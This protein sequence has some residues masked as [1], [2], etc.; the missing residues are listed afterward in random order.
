MSDGSSEVSDLVL[1]QGSN[2]LQS[3]GQLHLLT[4]TVLLQRHDD[5]R[6]RQVQ[7]QTGAE[8]DRC[9]DRHVQRQTGV[10]L[11]A[12][13][14]QTDRYLCDS[15]GVEHFNR[16]RLNLNSVLHQDCQ[17]LRDR[18]IQRETGTERWTGRE[19]QT[20]RHVKGKKKT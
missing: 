11:H 17:G 20:G 5:L 12:G 18:Q 19:R 7:R 9:R 15:V 3:V 6:E 10:D 16:T 14:N 2:L 8:T 4:R 13:G 1:Y